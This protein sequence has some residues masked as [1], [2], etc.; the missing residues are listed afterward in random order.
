MAVSEER[1]APD[2]AD[3]VLTMTLYKADPFC[4][5]Y[6]FKI[7]V[8]GCEEGDVEYVERLRVMLE[9]LHQ[10][11][12]NGEKAALHDMIQKKRALRR[13]QSEYVAQ[14]GTKGEVPN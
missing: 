3:A 5:S 2:A 6:G 10:H 12:E 8:D 13:S 9:I 11:I 14:C 4:L 1:P 7:E